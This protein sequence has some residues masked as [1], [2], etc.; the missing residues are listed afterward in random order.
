ML[1]KGTLSSQPSHF[2]S[3]TPWGVWLSW[4]YSPTTGLLTTDQKATLPRNHGLRLLKLWAQTNFWFFNLPGCLVPGQGSEKLS[5]IFHYEMD[6]N[7][8]SLFFLDAQ[9]RWSLLLSPAV[10]AE[11]SERQLTSWAWGSRNSCLS[12]LLWGCSLVLWPHMKLG[13]VGLWNYWTLLFTL[14][15]CPCSPVI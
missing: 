6:S 7:I 8:P 11:V 3:W 1:L 5:D 13:A 14:S 9:N 12:L 2:G 4:P 15:I 10:I